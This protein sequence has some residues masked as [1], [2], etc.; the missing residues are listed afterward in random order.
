MLAEQCR[1]EEITPTDAL[2]IL[3][4]EYRKLVTDAIDHL[5]TDLENLENLHEAWNSLLSYQK[6]GT[7]E[8]YLEAVDYYLAAYFTRFNGE[9]PLGTPRLKELKSHLMDNQHIHIL[10]QLKKLQSPIY[11]ELNKHHLTI[12]TDAD[13]QFTKAMEEVGRRLSEAAYQ[14][15]FLNKSTAIEDLFKYSYGKKELKN[16]TKHQIAKV[17]LSALKQ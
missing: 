14:L 15:H 10:K 2:T 3:Q 5:K 17:F 6:G 1:L 13:E 12:P 4:K 16:P 8:D 7:F 11:Y 9:K